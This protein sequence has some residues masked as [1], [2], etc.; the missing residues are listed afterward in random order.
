MKVH[1]VKD[2]KKK[3]KECSEIK[4]KNTFKGLPNLI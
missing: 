1:N 2:L 3:E 4:K